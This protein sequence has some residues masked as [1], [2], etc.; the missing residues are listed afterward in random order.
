[1]PCRVSTVL[2]FYHADVLQES[3][4]IVFKVHTEKN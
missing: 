2:Q 4:L 1:M 3:V